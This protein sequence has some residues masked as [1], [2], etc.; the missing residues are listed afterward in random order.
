MRESGPRKVGSQSLAEKLLRGAIQL[1]KG[2]S[3]PPKEPSLRLAGEDNKGWG[4]HYWKTSLSFSFLRE[5]VCA[6]GELGRGRD[7]RKTPLI[8]EPGA[9]FD[10]T[11]QRS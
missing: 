4:A 9:G 7:P 3:L 8:A 1:G 11:I 10:L 5:S 2:S 6:H